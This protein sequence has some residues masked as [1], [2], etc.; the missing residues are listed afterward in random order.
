MVRFYVTPIFCQTKMPKQDSFD[1][2]KVEYVIDMCYL[3][4]D[5]ELC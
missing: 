3:Y 5:S 2:I 1:S 4:N